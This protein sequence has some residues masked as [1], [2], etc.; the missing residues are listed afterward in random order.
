[1]K[2][3]SKKSGSASSFKS[4]DS[5][6]VSSEAKDRRTS[7]RDQLLASR[8]TMRSS[9]PSAEITLDP[10]AAQSLVASQGASGLP[11]ASSSSAAQSN[12]GG[13]ETTVVNPNNVSFGL[14]GQEGGGRSLTLTTLDV[15]QS[16][17]RLMM[18]GYKFDADENMASNMGAS[19]QTAPE[20][21]SGGEYRGR[22]TQTRV[23]GMLS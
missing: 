5:A 4:Y 19:F 8:R 22:G 1:M 6:S 17:E 18:S 11:P 23:R 3:G 16:A 12:G 15:A 13:K 2:K 10:A 9:S 21:M 7:T 20:N 14:Q